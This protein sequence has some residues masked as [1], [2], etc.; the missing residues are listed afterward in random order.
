MIYG[1]CLMSQNH[2]SQ[3]NNL[4]QSKSGLVLQQF[5]YD[6][7]GEAEPYVCEAR[8]YRS[9]V[10]TD[11]YM[12]RES[13]FG[14]ARKMLYLCRALGNA[15]QVWAAAQHSSSELGPKGRFAMQ[16]TLTRV[17]PHEGATKWSW[18]ES[19]P[20][21]NR[22]TIRFLHAY[23]GL[24]FRAAA[25]PKPPTATLSSKSSSCHRGLT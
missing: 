8:M 5:P 17:S 15:L 21:P 18:R 16:R 10:L 22:E 20:R 25:R 4:A 3:S 7:F 23:L 24:H 13:K 12:L 1:R 19:N 9:L 11:F 6:T 14:F 2:M